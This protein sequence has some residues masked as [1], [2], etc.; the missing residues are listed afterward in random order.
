MTPIVMVSGDFVPTGGMDRANYALAESLA[1]RGYPLH[2]VAHR[3]A[4][5]LRKHSNVSF[6]PVP[7]LL[8]SYWLSEPLLNRVGLRCGRQVM[9]QNGR[10]IVNGGNCRLGDLNWVHYVHAAYRPVNRMGWLRRCKTCLTHRTGMKAEK[11]ALSKARL[12]IANSERTRRDLLEHLSLQEDRVKTVYY[13]SDSDRFRPYSTVQRE[14]V[15]R[16][17]GWPTDRPLAVFLGALGDRRKGFDILLETWRRLCGNR[18]WDADL[19]VIGAGAELSRWQRLAIEA[20]IAERIR[21]LGFRLD[22]PRLLPACDVLLAPTRYEP[23][24]LGVQEAICCGLPAFV[25]REAGIAERY[26]AALA[27]FLLPN[28]DDITDLEHRLLVW[29]QNLEG[30]RPALKTFADH[31][32]SRT[33]DRMAADILD[34]LE[35]HPS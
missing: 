11:K 10:A 27:D 4:E 34:L 12:V 15:R 33:W 17:V 25:S 31:L 5:S 9:K 13:G 32:A 35:K 20:G 16:E 1:Q 8:G 22:V 14:T 23:Y 6:H 24:G 2:L 18:N 29:R 28:P 3:V 26:P 21:F 30:Y 19:V 7:K